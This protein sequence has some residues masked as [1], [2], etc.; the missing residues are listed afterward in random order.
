MGAGVLR[1][2]YSIGI[3]CSLLGHSDRLRYHS[4]ALHFRAS[5]LQHVKNVINKLIIIVETRH[6]EEEDPVW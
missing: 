5:T 1:W 4:S 3:K 2:C 6:K